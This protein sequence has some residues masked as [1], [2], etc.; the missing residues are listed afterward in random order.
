MQ[1]KRKWS[2]NDVGS[3]K[4]TFLNNSSFHGIQI[5]ILNCNFVHSYFNK[6]LSNFCSLNSACKRWSYTWCSKETEYVSHTRPWFKPFCVVKNISKYL[7]ILWPQFLNNFGTF[8]LWTWVS[9]V[10]PSAGSP[11]HLGSFHMIFIVIAAFFVTLMIFNLIIQ[12]KSLNCFLSYHFKLHLGLYITVV[13]T[14][15]HH[16]SH[17]KDLTVMHDK[18]LRPLS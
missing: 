4:S 12:N 18:F 13:S 3:S 10:P 17:D 5:S 11:V 8:A 14:F 16:A 9:A 15:I 7:F 6:H 1:P 2:R